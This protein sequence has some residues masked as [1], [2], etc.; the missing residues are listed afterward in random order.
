MDIA[1]RGNDGK[2]KNLNVRHLVSKL[3]NL[4]LSILP[5][6]LYNQNE[7]H[8]C[9]PPTHRLGHRI[10]LARYLAAAPFR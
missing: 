2:Y 10:M 6:P 8:R 1:K 9:H 4:S 3:E 5:F 7:G